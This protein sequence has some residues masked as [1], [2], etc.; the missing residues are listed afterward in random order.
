[1][2]EWATLQILPTRWVQFHLFIGIN[3]CRVISFSFTLFVCLN[4]TAFI[5]VECAGEE[6]PIPTYLFNTREICFPFH[7]SPCIPFRWILNIYKAYQLQTDWKM[8]NRNVYLIDIRVNV[9]Q[10]YRE[11]NRK[12]ANLWC[13][14][15]F[16]CTNWGIFL[17]SLSLYSLYS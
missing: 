7:F 4:F 14:R 16:K 5:S 17:L 13:W 15:Y 12:A 11:K 1:M 10:S 8:S 9:K 3:G 2:D 6:E